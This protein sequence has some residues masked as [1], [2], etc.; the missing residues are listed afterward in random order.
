MILFC[1][2]T[3]VKYHLR[4]N[5]ERK[6]HELNYVNFELASSGKEIDDKL[7]GLEWITPEFKNN[8][9]EE[10]LLIKETKSYLYND[11]R[12]NI[13]KVFFWNYGTLLFN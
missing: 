7:K 12:N 4:F 3:T 9:G 8:P 11:H 2:Y 1:L 13:F 6:F 10:I 5:E